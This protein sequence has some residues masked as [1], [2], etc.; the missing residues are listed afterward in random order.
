MSIYWLIADTPEPDGYVASTSSVCLLI[1]DTP[2][3]DG[4]VASSSSK[5]VCSGTAG[6]GQILAAFSSSFFDLEVFM[7]C[8]N[9]S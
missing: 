1:A 8:P 5:P 3:P 4:C 7:N 6:N 2:E 9:N